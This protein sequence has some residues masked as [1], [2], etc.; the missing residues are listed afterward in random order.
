MTQ[1]CGTLDGE[2]RGGI[3][4]EDEPHIEREAPRPDEGH[5]EALLVWMREILIDYWLDRGQQSFL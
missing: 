2:G 4:I 5:H 1:N 3:D